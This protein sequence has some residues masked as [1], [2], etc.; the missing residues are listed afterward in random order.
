MSAAED[1]RGGA[2]EPVHQ[3]E[4]LRRPGGNECRQG[5][6]QREEEREQQHGETPVHRDAERGVTGA[7][8][9][10]Q[11]EHA[12][13]GTGGDDRNMRH[14]AWR[15]DRGDGGQHRHR[16]TRRIG[17]EGA[18]HPPDGLRHDGGGDRLQPLQHAR[19]DRLLM[20]RD[21]IA[22]GQHDG[23]RGERETRPGRHRA[24]ESRL[25]EADADP[26]LAGGGPR[27]HLAE[28]DE[29]GIGAILDPAPARDEGLA[30]I[31]DMRDRPAERGQP[32]QEEGNEY[33]RHGLAP[34]AAARPARAVRAACAA[35]HRHRNT[36]FR[37]Y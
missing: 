31:A 33:P 29:V 9:R 23:R 12:R 35:A 24:G 25:R 18:R 2:V 11:E 8:G 14:D 30:E 26:H 21:A 10:A 32:Q 36:L 37:R 3:L 28:R 13:Q 16:G 17:A 4:R 20:G 27:Q 19:R 5:G 6:K 7:C 1:Q 15:Q 34:R 22:E